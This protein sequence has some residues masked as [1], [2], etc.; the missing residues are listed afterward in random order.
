VL[1]IAVLVVGFGAI[2][3]G[4]RAWTIRRAWLQTVGCFDDPV[5]LDRPLRDDARALSEE[6]MRHG[7]EPDRWLWFE[8]MQWAGLVLQRADGT[9][10][11]ILSGD[12]PP[13][14]DFVSHVVGGATLV[15]EPTAFGPRLP[16]IVRQ[17]LG[18]LGPDALIAAHDRALDAVGRPPLVVRSPDVLTAEVLAWQRESIEELLRSG[19]RNAL[20]AAVRLTF[21]IQKDTTPLIERPAEL[22]RLRPTA[23]R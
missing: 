1:I 2:V 7:F 5:R 18:D 20:L 13:G 23:P 16:S 17:G 14:Y 4:T 3:F 21:N 9:T 6:I 19:W 12:R 22:E 11:L 8:G 15:T 10:A